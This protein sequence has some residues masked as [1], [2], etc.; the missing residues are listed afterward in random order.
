MAT[1]ER[2]LGAAI[3]RR[4]DPRFIT[5]RGQYVDD[6]KLPLMTYAA[7]VRSPH[8][9]AR[10][11]GIDPTAAKARPGVVAVFTGQDV[12][13]GGLPCGWML[14]DI[15][16]PTHPVLAQ[17]KVRYVGDPVAIVIGESAYA[18]KDGADAVKVDYEP[19]PGISDAAK[20]HD[21]SA[22][23]LF[24]EIT[25]NQSFYWTIGDKAATDA[26]FASAAKVVKQPIINQRL[27]PNA[28]E[29][30]ACV[31]SFSPATND[32]TLWVTSQN[33]HVHRLLMAAFILGIPESKMR[34]IAPDVGGGFGSKIFVYNEEVVACWASKATGR[35]VK[36]TSERREAFQNDAHGRD[37]ITEAEM[38]FD[39][40]GKITGLR[41]KTHANLG[42][43]LST[44]APLIPSFLYGPLLSGVYKIPAIFCEVWGV[45]TNTAPVDAYRGAGRPEAT[46]LLERLMDRAAAELKTDP[47]ELRRK[48][49]IPKFTDGTPYQTPVAFAYDSGDYEPAL[50]RALELSGYAQARKDQ[51]AARKSG[52]YIGI[53]VSTYIE[54]CGPAPSAVAGSLGAGAGLWESGSVRVHPTGAVTV[55]TGS[56]SHGQGHETT[57]A[58]IVADNLGIPME[59]VEIV[60][61]DTAQIPFGM[62]SY[63]SRSACVGGS[64]IVRSLDKVKEKGRKIAA[65]LLEA[66][67]NDLDFAGGKWSVKGSPDKSK[68]WGEVALMAYLAHNIPA[69][70]EPGL[71][72]TSF[73]DPTN[74][75][76]PFGAHVAVVEVDPDTGE[77]T[78]LKY[79][80]VDDVG[81]VINPMIVDGMV[82]GGI[83]QG[84]AQALWE[85]GIYTED[86]QLVSGTMMDYAL[87]KA[88]QLPSYQTDR[89]VTPSPINPLGVKGAGETGT[90]AATPT[91]ANAV[92][93]ALAPFGV[94]HLDMPLTPAKIWKAVAAARK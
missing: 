82:H 61:G 18:A 23:Q 42:A 71:E 90:I 74:F 65:H 24:D 80:A 15:K 79:V 66:N 94:T 10:I 36:W 85:H 13:V 87:P 52:R 2:L 19:L 77:T 33:P 7:F 51:E 53:G 56:H 84:V 12:Q 55:F 45:L 68:A 25:S 17:G 6:V 22:P 75:T 47:T 35:P 29:P 86:G 14:P 89:T 39:G 27:I 50:K 67:E 88:D 73:Y 57:F 81:K 49:F 16:V 70:M 32:L 43:Y 26:A 92:L 64:A 60:H 4:E 28:M 93:D 83:A 48:N 30:R 62:G 40:N 9:H 38:A 63:G 5:G 69:G 20:A 11:R 46:F 31:A 54:A 44:F 21:K 91:V 8:A 41:V 78:I 58:Q 37:H 3:K 76:F 59:Q 1:T 34:V 72:A